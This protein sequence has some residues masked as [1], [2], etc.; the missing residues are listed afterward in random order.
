ME[1]I[2]SK[3]LNITYYSKS[4]DYSSLPDINLKLKYNFFITPLNSSN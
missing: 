2:C 3:P 4:I 1:L